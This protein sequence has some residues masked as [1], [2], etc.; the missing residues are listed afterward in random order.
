LLKPFGVA[1]ETHAPVKLRERLGGILVNRSALAL[2]LPLD[3]KSF[4]VR[5]PD[6]KIELREQT[7]AAIVKAVHEG[8]SDIGMYTA[9]SVDDT[10]LESFDYAAD[11]MVVDLS[12]SHPDPMPG[13]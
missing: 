6:L 1:G 12:A 2:F 5:F 3:L 13:T 9:G 11:S 7:S 4:T 10:G 8:Q